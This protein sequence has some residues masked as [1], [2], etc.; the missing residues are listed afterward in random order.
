MLSHKGRNKEQ[1]L[2]FG[3]GKVR[4]AQA[5]RLG[6]MDEVKAMRERLSDSAA[7]GT[8]KKMTDE[9]LQEFREVVSDVFKG[10]DVFDYSGIVE[11]QSAAMEALSKVSGT[12]RPAR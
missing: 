6:S 2:V 5:E 10:G 1:Q 4:A 8:S 3:S 7:S 11:I 12:R 9:L